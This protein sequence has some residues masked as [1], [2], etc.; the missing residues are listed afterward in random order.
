MK[1]VKWVLVV[2]Y[3]Y[4][5]LTETLIGR[6]VQPEPIFRGLFWEIQ[7]GMWSDIL[8]NILLFIPLGLLIGGWK[9]VLIGFLLSCGIELIQYFGRL[10]YC[11]LDDIFN[12][13]IGAGIGAG[14]NVLIGKSVG[15][16]GLRKWEDLP[17]FMRSDEVRPYW[18]I[19]NRKRGQL[20]LKRAFDLVVSV[21]LLIILAI[22]MAIIAIMIKVED[23]GPVLYRQER[24]TTYGKRF[25]IHKFRTMVVN[26]DKIG[27]AVTV[28]ADPRI[29]KTGAKL[30]RVRLDE[31][32]QVF[33]VIKGDMSFVGTRP[34][35]VKFVK[36]YK[37]EYYATLLLPA[38]ITSE[39]SIEYKDEDKFLNAADNVE[40]EYIEAVLP[41]KMKYN[42]TSIL[43]FSFLH[44]LAVIFRTVVEV[45]LK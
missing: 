12:N 11:E 37:P 42:L 30:R 19:L 23:P 26:A 6:P 25:R 14:I 40:E 39:A 38:G 21:V 41:G 18:E 8:L 27:T 31:L 9:G 5:I 4:F 22:P 7:N 1:Y 44:E 45:L 29:T 3:I 34:E 24:V 17:A 28:G 16:M 2:G 43:N 36:R 33:D 35:A 32:P 13:T 20:I 10:G 15:E